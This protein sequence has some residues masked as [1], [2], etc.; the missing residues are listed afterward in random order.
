MENK[1]SLLYEKESYKLRGLFMQI[2]NEI[3]P[4]LKESIY[5]NVFEELLKKHEISYKRE[6]TLPVEFE[7]KQVGV[8]RPDF[9]V[10]DKILVELKSISQIPKVDVQRVY[11]YLKSSGYKLGFIVN[12][13]MPKLQIIRRIFNKNGSVKSVDNPL[14]PRSSAGQSLLDILIGLALITLGMGVA[15]ILVFGGQGLLIDRNNAVE[16]RILA[17]EGVVA[18]RFIIETDWDAVSDGSYGLL[19]TNG[20]WQLSENED[21]QSIFTRSVTITTIDENIK[22]IVSEVNWSGGPSRP[23]ETTL[24]TLVTNWQ[25]PSLP[26]G[27]PGDTGGGGTSGD[28]QNPRTLGSVD[29]GP[30]NAATDVDVLNKIVYLSATASDKKKP[31]FFIVDATDAENPFVVSELNTGP[32]LRGIDVSSSYAY[33]ANEDGEAQ[34]QIIDVSNI[35]DPVI[36]TSYTLPDSD[37]FGVT[38]FFSDLKVY[39]GTEESSGSEFYIID[40]STPSSPLSLGAFEIGA[41]VNDI[42]VSGSR[43]YLAT[44]KG[45]A[46]L[47]VLDI[48]DPQN[49]TLLGASYSEDTQSVFSLRPA[50]TFLGPGQDFYISD[51]T[52]PDTITTI[53]SFETGGTVNDMIARDYLM[54]LGTSNSNEEFQVVDISNPTNPTL[55]SS[56]NFSQIGTGIDYEDNIVYVSVRSNDALRII[57]ST[58]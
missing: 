19:F 58:P 37:A 26:P 54:F 42:Y 2:Y 53:G 10:Y 44:D 23:L 6:P 7:D 39:V 34:L 32:S 9:L 55:H 15:V 49:I 38:V 16:A 40:V 4:G 45:G 13:G 27:D 11:Q 24:V 43:A 47:T 22:E 51:T 8:Y 14:N 57:T 29:L 48:S 33:V 35:S 31:D 28:W 46:G 17:H 50:L 21:E 41:H 56:F 3:G 30:G 20:T 1:K 5:G 18:A 36:I 12:F 25:N 52:D